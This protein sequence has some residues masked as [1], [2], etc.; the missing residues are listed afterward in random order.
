[1]AVQELQTTKEFEELQTTKE[2]AEVEVACMAED[3]VYGM[4]QEEADLVIS[5]TIRQ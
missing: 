4:A 3:L 5:K 2:F 1:M